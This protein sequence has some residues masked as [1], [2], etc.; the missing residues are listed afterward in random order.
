MRKNGSES[1]VFKVDRD[2]R[3]V[4]GQ[5]F[6]KD[7]H[8]RGRLRRG[9]VKIAGISY[10]KSDDRLVLGVF[11]DVINY[12]CRM[13]RVQCGGEYTERIAHG[14]SRALS[15]VIYSDDPVHGAKLQIIPGLHA[16]GR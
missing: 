7:I 3:E 16:K 15:S 11:F 10:N 2:R 5:N 6:Q 12:I 13:H 1:F 8:V 14:K 9:T 4:L